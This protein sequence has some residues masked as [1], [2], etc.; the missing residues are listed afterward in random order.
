MLP[1]MGTRAVA[2]PGGDPAPGDLPPPRIEPWE[3]GYVGPDLEPVPRRAHEGVVP[4]VQGALVTRTGGVGRLT[5]DARTSRPQGF[6]AGKTIYLSP[7]HGWTWDPDSARWET[8]RPNSL[9]IVEDF[10]NAE[11]VIQFLIPYLWNASAHVVPVREVDLNDQ[12]VVLDDADGLGYPDDGAVE[13]IGDAALFSDSTLA[14]YGRLTGPLGGT[15]NP[16]AQGGNRL[17]ES[18]AEPTARVRYTFEVPEDGFYNVYVS[19]SAWSG[20]A[21]DAHYV[22]R[23]PGGEAHFRVNQQHHGGTWVLLGRFWFAAGFDPDR[24]AVELHNDSADAGS[25][26]STDAVRLGGGLGIMDRGGGPSLFPR[27]LENSRYHAQYAGAPAAVYDTSGTDRSD[28]VGARSRFAAWVHEDG[29]D[30][31]YFSWHSN[32]GGGTGT[33]IY[34]YWPNSHGYCDGT[35]ATAGSAELA[36]LVLGEIIGDV[37]AVWD[38]A[39]TDRGRR[40]A[41]FGELNPSNNPEMPAALLEAAFHDLPEDVEDLK[42]AAFRRILGR[43]VYQGI[44]RY[45][46]ARD[47]VAP[48]FVPEPPVAPAARN[49]GPGQVEISWEPPD[50]DAAGGDPPQR[51]RLYQG[52]N[53]QAFDEGLDVGDVRQVTLDDLAPGEVRFFRVTAVN[54]GG[55][56]LPSPVV[57]VMASPSGLAPLLIVDGFDREDA[58]LL[59]AQ[60]TGTYLGTVDRL[61]LERMRGSAGV[62][63]HGPE[64]ARF[65]VPFDSVHHRGAAAL[66]LEQYEVVD[67]LAGRGVSATRSLTASLRD[68]LSTYVASGGNL[69][70]SGSHVASHLQAGDA[71]D[72]AFLQLTLWTDAAAGGGGYAVTPTAGA[73]LD[74]VGDFALH[75]GAPLAGARGYDVGTPDGL[76][77]T[78]GTTAFAA[79][80]G[81]GPPAAL[82]SEGPPGATVLLGFPLEGVADDEQ[83]AE[84]MGRILAFFEVE[85]EVAPDAGPGVDAGP[86]VDAADAGDATPTCQDCP[87]DE[88]CGC[89]AGASPGSGAFPGSGASGALG[90]TLLFLALGLRRRRSRHPRSARREEGEGA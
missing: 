25:N 88:G 47:G 67:Y 35:D 12:M 79:Y 4:P 41:W 28:D 1:G 34:I 29:E 21:S 31:A 89:A 81:G 49:V 6:L 86:A 87:C 2:N 44:V 32:A 53:G 36:D 61:V 18:A 11:H 7:G 73:L 57:G 71:A 60:N 39:W 15:T 3:R 83:R 10:S 58:G 40:C 33:S 24:G 55:E 50:P 13:E 69:L 84:I 51:Y 82:R 59:W 74:G 62:R 80:G 45:F 85:P 19:Y 22:V 65:E 64:A 66:V 42:E 63:R 68:R 90:L 56:S 30:A 20:R 38:P 37:Q 9:G 26:V 77:G 76:T 72:Q 17:L 52:P 46:A 5:K 43:A 8:Q 14:G 75:D 78:Q 54:A 23:H 27:Y 48:V 16:F 70:V